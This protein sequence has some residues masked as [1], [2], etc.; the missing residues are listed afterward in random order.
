MALLKMSFLGSAP[1]SRDILNFFNLS[2]SINLISL[3]PAM[4]FNFDSTFSPIISIY[5]SQVPMVL[6]MTVHGMR[7][8]C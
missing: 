8:L 4:D 1:S 2:L 5:I 6:T 3:I 7:A